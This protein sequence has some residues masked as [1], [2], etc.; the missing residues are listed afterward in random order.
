ML[1]MEGWFDKE[2]LAVSGDGYGRIAI[3]VRDQSSTSTGLK[4][5]LVAPLVSQQ[6]GLSISPA[7]AGVEVSWE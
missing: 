2:T 5:L 6:G 4:I 1:L 3:A 7:G